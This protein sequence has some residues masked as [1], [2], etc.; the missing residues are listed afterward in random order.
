MRGAGGLMSGVNPS[1]IIC[2]GVEG[3][4]L[5]LGLKPM[6]KKGKKEQPTLTVNLFLKPCQCSGKSARGGRGVG[7]A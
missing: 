3:V 7:T 2:P 5:G 4:L 6:C 1:A